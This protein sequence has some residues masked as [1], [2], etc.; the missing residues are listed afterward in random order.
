MAEGYS[1][2]SDQQQPLDYKTFLELYKD[3]MLEEEIEELGKG[4]NK[5]DT[6]YYAG[7]IPL[8]TREDI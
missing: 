8:R 3:Q 2:N 4:K 7:A 6:I 5:F 1:D